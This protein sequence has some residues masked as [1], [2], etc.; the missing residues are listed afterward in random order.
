MPFP[1]FGSDLSVYDIFGALAVGAGIVLPTPGKLRDAAYLLRLMHQHGVT[2][3]N[4]VPALMEM[5]VQY[6]EDTGSR[7]PVSLRLV[8][9][10]GDWIPVGL[11]DRIRALCDHHV[12]IVSLGGATEAAIWSISYPIQSVD[13]SW[14][15]IPYG[16]P[17]ANQRFH[18]LDAR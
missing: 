18:V 2:L 7:L 1:R 11:P 3:W 16:R 13:P 4:S 15:S 10:S 6:A 17:L 5:L 8:F 9:M 12:E 14:S